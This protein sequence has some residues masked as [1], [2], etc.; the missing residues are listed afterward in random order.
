M[1]KKLLLFLGLLLFLSITASAHAHFNGKGHVDYAKPVIQKFINTDCVATNTCELISFKLITTELEVWF[2]GDDEKHPS[3]GTTMVAEYQ[4]DLVD[5]LE[6]FA[7]VQFIRGCLIY[8]IKMD[9]GQIK[10]SIASSFEAFFGKKEIPM[11][12]RDW[13][14]DSVDTDP[15]YN[16]YPDYGR[17]YLYRWNKLAGSYENSTQKFYGEEKP[18]FP[19]LYIKDPLKP[20]VSY[21]SPDADNLER[22]IDA[23]LEFRTCIYRTAD[24]PI[25]TVESNVDFAEPIKCFNW[26]Y[27][28]I[29]NWDLKKFETKDELVFP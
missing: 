3:Y 5:S 10:R 26:K 28:Y 18:A 29:Y 20:S 7:I 9:D 22:S 13:V 15:V 2:A 27:F 16:S 14:I 25:E 19:Q 6:K 17:H 24:I 11:C 12:F 21:K 8:S 4:T 1:E 23:S